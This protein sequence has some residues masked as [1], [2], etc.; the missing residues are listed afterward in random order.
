MCFA[1]P[2]YLAIWLSGYLDNWISGARSQ[3]QSRVRAIWLSGYMLRKRSASGTATLSAGYLVAIW[4]SG[5]IVRI[6]SAKAAA[7][8]SGYLAIWLSS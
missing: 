7:A 1:V 3:R 8:L 2:R 4:L 6:R 5:Y